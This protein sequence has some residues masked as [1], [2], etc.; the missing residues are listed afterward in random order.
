MSTSRRGILLIC[1]QLI[2][3]TLCVLFGLTHAVAPKVVQV[4]WPDY[5][6][7]NS[8]DTGPRPDLLPSAGSV[9]INKTVAD[10]PSPQW[11]PCKQTSKTSYVNFT[12]SPYPIRRRENVT[13]GLEGFLDEDIPEGTVLEMT[14]SKR[15]FGILPGP[16]FKLDVCKFIAEQFPNS[17]HPIRCPLNKYAILLVMNALQKM[18]APSGDGTPGPAATFQTYVPWM[19]IPGRYRMTVR[20]RAGSHD[21]TCAT[22]MVRI[23]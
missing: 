6:F 13:V 16:S 3:A 17:P 2:V 9:E 18:S 12:F 14:S 1:V 8:D 19:V 11:F 10:L 21:I 23:E 20:L 7:N 4:E 22:T 5:S 15:G